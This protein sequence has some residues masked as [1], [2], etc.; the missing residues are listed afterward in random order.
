MA[1]TAH[2]VHT[3]TGGALIP[4]TLIGRLSLG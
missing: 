3:H 1:R 4:G 2:I